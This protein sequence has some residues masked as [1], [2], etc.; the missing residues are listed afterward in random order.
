ML[1]EVWT[2][3]TA[4]Q[5]YAEY[6]FK[7]IGN[8]RGVSTYEYTAAAAAA[9]AAPAAKKSAAAAARVLVVQL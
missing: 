4:F 3:V 1:P 5:L 7:I 6:I 8:Y 2:V 9:G